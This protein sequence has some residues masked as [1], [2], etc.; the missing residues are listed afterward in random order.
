[1]ATIEITGNAGGDAELK[2]IKGAKGDFAVANFSLGET[3]REN[4]DGQW[5]NGET[6]WWK[7][8]AT[9]SLAEVCADMVTKGKKLFIKGDLKAFEYKG[10]DGEIKSG[11]EVRAKMIAEVGT[12]KRKS[13]PAQDEVWG[14][15]GW[16]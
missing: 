3:P 15:S 1:M 14:G 5:V 9:G 4:K 8:S 6:V 7:V 16:N 11:W 12:L 2:F 10:R 13:A